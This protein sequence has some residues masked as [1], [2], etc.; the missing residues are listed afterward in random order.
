MGGLIKGDV[1]VVPFPF[2]DLTGVKNRPAVIVTTFPGQGILL[3]QITSKFAGVDYEVS[4][5][6]SDFAQGKLARQSYARPDRLFTFNSQ[7]IQSHVGA[8]KPNKMQE[9]VDHIV[10]FV[11]S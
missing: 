4:L 11:T 3:C 1:V 5:Q 6:L 2:S 10:R 9:I 8:L 7:L